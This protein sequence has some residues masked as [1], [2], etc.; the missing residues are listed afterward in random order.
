[1]SVDVSVLVPT[2]A[3]ETYGWLT[4]PA[5]LR[6]WQLIAGRTDLRV[7]GE[8]R[9]LIAPGHTAVGAYT[10][11]EPARRLAYAWGWEGAEEV[12]PGS[13]TVEVT[14]APSAGGTEVRLVHDGLSDVQAKAHAEGWEHFLQR[15]RTVTIIGDAGPDEVAGLGDD[16]NP[17]TAAEASLAICLRVLRAVGTSHGADKTPCAKF[18]V[19]DLLDHLLG[20]LTSLAGMAGRPFEAG[21][22]TP[23]ERVADAGLRSIEAWRAR[24][25]DGTVTAR[26]GE[27]PAELA[28]A[29]LSVE[30][31]VHGWDFAVATGVDFKADDKLSAYVLDLARG[32]ITP[33]VRDGEQFAA[34]VPVGP[35]VNTLERLVA[36]TGRAV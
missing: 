7:G 12:P 33:Q 17:L 29:I 9:W 11:V 19:D 6:R 3:E 24:G 14:L 13:S 35:D 5:K 23:E 31:L 20:S 18:T 4:E 36:F 2:S 10:A 32:L 26:L 28:S 8:F 27:I 21:D 22:G 16:P 25:L 15:L 1:M 30:F 34:E